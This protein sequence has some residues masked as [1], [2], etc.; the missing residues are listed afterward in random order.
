MTTLC[1]WD[2]RAGK[3]FV[4][5]IAFLKLFT[6]LI[7]VI[8]RRICSYKW[9]KIV[10]IY[11]T[12]PMKFL[13]GIFVIFMFLTVL[14]NLMYTV[15][16]YNYFV[17]VVICLCTTVEPLYSEHLLVWRFYLDKTISI[18]QVYLTHFVN[19]MDWMLCFIQHSFT[20]S[21][22]VISGMMKETR[23][24]VKKKGSS[25][26]IGFFVHLVFSF[27]RILCSC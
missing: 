14:I 12:I 1:F 16:I 24:P 23:V 27:C 5:I 6:F 19:E 18:A 20:Y 26:Q 11:S 9:S 7:Q 10:V 25:L 3:K 13:S 22:M 4:D 2:Y 17:I 15:N 21:Q 8:I